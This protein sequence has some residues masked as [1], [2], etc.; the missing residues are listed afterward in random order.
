MPQT[1]TDENHVFALTD[2]DQ[3]L[4]QLT[5]ITAY[6]SIGQTALGLVEIGKM[7]R[8]TEMAKEEALIASEGD[9]E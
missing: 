9:E 3:V 8:E 1:G 6:F 5:R 4:E 2:L 7:M